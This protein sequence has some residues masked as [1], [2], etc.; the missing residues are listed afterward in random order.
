M[1]RGAVRCLLRRCGATWPFYREHMRLEENHGCCLR[2]RRTWMTMTG[3]PWMPRLPQREPAGPWPP[4]R[5]AW[6]GSSPAR[7]GCEPLGQPERPAWPVGRSDQ[8]ARWVV[9]VA[10][11]TAVVQGVAV[12][13]AERR[14]LPRRSTRSGLEMKGRPNATMSAPL[15]RRLL[16]GPGQPLF[17][18]QAPLP[19]AAR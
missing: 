5:P 1:G 18:I 13:P 6:T 8:P 15:A 11:G 12:Q 7:D 3:L 14:V 2:R 17:T 19:P 16:P 9:G 4:A 10:L